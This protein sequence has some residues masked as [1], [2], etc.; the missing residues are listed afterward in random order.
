MFKSLS[1]KMK[2]AFLIFLISYLSLLSDYTYCQQESSYNFLKLDVDARSSALAGNF[3]SVQNDVNTIFYNPAGLA[4][5][6][7]TNASIGFFK[8]LLDINAGNAA[9]SQKFKDLGYFGA[10]IRYINY[11][12]FD[13]YNENYENIGTFS[14]NDLALS[15]SYSNKYQDFLSYGGSIKFIYSNIDEYNSVAMAFDFGLLYFI[16]EQSLTLGASLLNL[17][18]QLKS[19]YGTREKLPIDLRVG[20]SKKLDYLPLQLS[21]G[22]VNLVDDYDKFYD[23]FKNIVVGGELSVSDNILLRIGYNN[24]QRQNLKTGSSTGIAGFSA[25]FGIKFLDNYRVDYSLN[26]M[27]NIGETHRFNINFY[28]K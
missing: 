2:K 18:T 23:R 14:S 11:G 4:T 25:G 17:G 12:S 16:P 7:N 22:F 19:Y 8:Y 13:K 15:L 26:S 3:M 20:F 9:Y 21:I 1:K 6:E 5:L 27:G 24:P 28:L 10:G